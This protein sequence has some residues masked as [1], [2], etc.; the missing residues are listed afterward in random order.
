MNLIMIRNVTNVYL[1]FLLYL[2][3]SSSAQTKPKLTFDEFFDSTTFKHLSFSPNGQ[4]L[5][6]Q[7]TNPSWNTSSYE[8]S[9]WIY[10]IQQQTKT[11]ITKNPHQSIKPQWS[12]SG[13]SD[14]FVT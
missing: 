10:D 9:L 6:F 7:T 8:N 2:F 14:C 12:P 3:T 13:K 5:L 4:Y 11:L 1:I